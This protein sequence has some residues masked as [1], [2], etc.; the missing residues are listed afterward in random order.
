MTDKE[1]QDNIQLIEL[2]K[3]MVKDPT[4]PGKYRDALALELKTIKEEVDKLLVIAE[5]L[6]KEVITEEDY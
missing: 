2:M 6:R 5:V 3:E 4:V 1:H